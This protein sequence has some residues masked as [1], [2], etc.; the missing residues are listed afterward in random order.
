L[1]ELYKENP[2]D[3]PQEAGLFFCLS[4]INK[5]SFMIASSQKK[6]GKAG[7]RGDFLRSEIGN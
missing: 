2:H 5:A 7:R 4:A 6:P 1:G 3:A